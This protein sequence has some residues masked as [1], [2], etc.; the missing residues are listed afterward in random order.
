MDLALHLRTAWMNR[1]GRR[2]GA[3]SPP[4]VPVAPLR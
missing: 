2:R 1:V 4:P 3:R